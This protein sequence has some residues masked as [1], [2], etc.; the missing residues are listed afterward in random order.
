MSET[1]TQGSAGV[2][3]IGRVQF[4]LGMTFLGLSFVLPFVVAPIIPFLGL[5]NDLTVTLVTIAVVSGEVC[6]ILTAMLLGKSFV[7]AVKG[8]AIEFLAPTG[9]ISR[10]RYRIGLAL[11][12]LSIL[13]LYI[14]AALPYAGFGADDMVWWSWRL[15]VAGEVFLIVGGL[16]LG[17]R[18]WDRLGSLFE[19]ATYGPQNGGETATAQAGSRTSSP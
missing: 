6:F 8:K 11:F 5:E 15:L 13:P 4:G 7:K 3:R 9:P 19:Y 12:V 1:Q 10:R 16:A 2:A 17:P 18:F 14:N